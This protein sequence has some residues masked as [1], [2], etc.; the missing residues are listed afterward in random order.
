MELFH[1]TRPEKVEKPVAV[2]VLTARRIDTA[3]HQ[4]VDPNTLSISM[5]R[6]H[7]TTIY[8]TALIIQINIFR[9]AV[10]F[11]NPLKN[12]KTHFIRQKRWR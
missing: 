6:P 10:K 9:K 5:G 12:V 11:I 3:G 1:S 2:M 4:I 8:Y 7:S